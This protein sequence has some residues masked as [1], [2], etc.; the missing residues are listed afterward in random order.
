MNKGVLSV[1][2]GPIQEGVNF[3]AKTPHHQCD[4]SH[5]HHHDHSQHHASNQVTSALAKTDAIGYS[6]G[7]G[8]TAA[9]AQVPLPHFGRINQVGSTVSS[10]APSDS[11]RSSSTTTAEDSPSGLSCGSMST[12]TSTPSPTLS[13]AFS[14]PVQQPHQQ[15]QPQ[16]QHQQQPHHPQSE[17]QQSHTQ[18]H[19]N[20]APSVTR[21]VAKQTRSA[22][23]MPS[24]SESDGISSSAGSSA[25]SLPSGV[26]VPTNANDWQQP[27][28]DAS[29]VIA[30][31]DDM[32]TAPYVTGVA[33]NAVLPQGLNAEVPAGADPTMGMGLFAEVATHPHIGNNTNEITETELSHA[34]QTLAKFAATLDEVHRTTLLNLLFKMSFEAVQGRPDQ[35]QALLELQALALSSQHVAH[36]THPGPAQADT[37][38]TREADVDAVCDADAKVAMKTLKLYFSR[39]SQAPTEAETVAGNVASQIPLVSHTAPVNQMYQTHD[40][41]Q[42]QHLHQYQQGGNLFDPHQSVYHA[43]QQ[44][45]L[46]HQHHHQYQAHH[47]HQLHVQV[48]GLLETLSASANMTT[49]GLHQPASV[50]YHNP[51]SDLQMVDVVELMRYSRQHAI[52]QHMRNYPD[53]VDEYGAHQV[54]EYGRPVRTLNPPSQ[55]RPKDVYDP[56]AL[57][58]YFHASNR[59]YSE[60]HPSALYMPGITDQMAKALSSKFYETSDPIPHSIVYH[61]TVGANGVPTDKLEPTID[62]APIIVANIEVDIDVASNEIVSTYP[63]PASLDAIHAALSSSS[64][65]SGEVPLASFIA[66]EVPHNEVQEYARRIKAQRAEAIVR[67]NARRSLQM[68]QQQLQLQQ[69][70][71]QQLQRAK[72][73]Y[74][75]QRHESQDMRQQLVSEPTGL[76]K[77]VSAPA[78]N[79]A[80]ASG[81][82]MAALV[83]SESPQDDLT[84]DLQALSKSK[85]KLSQCESVTVSLIHNTSSSAIDHTSAARSARVVSTLAMDLPSTKASK[86]GM[87]VPSVVRDTVLTSSEAS[88]QNSSPTNSDKDFVPKDLPRLKPGLD[89]AGEASDSVASPPV[90]STVTEELPK[91]R[92]AYS[93]TSQRRGS[94][95]NIDDLTVN[96]ISSPSL[97]APSIVP[98]PSPTANNLTIRGKR[99]LGMSSR[100]NGIQAPDSSSLGPI[101]PVLAP[102]ALTPHP[103][104]NNYPQ[105]PASSRATR[106]MIGATGALEAA[107]AL[108]SPIARRYPTRSSTSF[109]GPGTEQPSAS[110]SLCS[111]SMVV[112]HT[113]LPSPAL[114]PRVQS[115]QNGRKATLK[116]S[117]ALT[118]PLPSPGS[119]SE[120]TFFPP[121]GQAVSNASFGSARRSKNVHSS[122]M[123]TSANNSTQSTRSP[124]AVNKLVMEECQ[125]SPQPFTRARSNAGTQAK[126]STPALDVL[127]VAVADD[128][129]P[130][131][132]SSSG[133]YEQPTPL[134][135]TTELASDKQSRASPS[136]ATFS[137]LPSLASSGESNLAAIAS[138]CTVR[139]SPSVSSCG[140]S[141]AKP[142]S[143]PGRNP[144]NGDTQDGA[145]PRLGRKRSSTRTLSKMDAPPTASAPCNSAESPTQT[146]DSGAGSTKRVK[147]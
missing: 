74:S 114:P 107:T 90:S 60:V 109:Q 12:S 48:P 106:N 112:P 20:S 130:L 92:K 36:S 132:I 59:G 77:S 91:L 143:A 110:S 113:P 37:A 123:S 84:Q 135:M 57:E 133:Q 7:S 53:I 98:L 119:S 41:R 40:Q 134:A 85:V 23:K 49:N 38:V 11:E 13:N 21:S 50:E 144:S 122:P 51:R 95:S 118:F 29:E 73:A 2:Q 82:S 104:M 100:R 127:K 54:D 8:A 111:A 65:T 83:T 93:R 10:C 142:P 68:Q 115:S 126:N 88:P 16:Q 46:Y 18:H 102:P 31:S 146:G 121:G 22:E 17:P 69:Q 44:A 3:S 71:Q 35:T 99:T 124:S 79:Q 26:S 32:T 139:D 89:V 63:L 125:Q 4:P 80:P 128:L 131:I 147:Q 136:A 75:Q 129:S 62:I 78:G 34:L 145:S 33:V 9:S 43:Q 97:G 70:L 52:I 58:A 96:S 138:K 39:M 66:H 6:L 103:T 137:V 25:D 1:D 76:K 47:P 30:A 108:P 14:D 86:T 72:L 105:L 116:A 15:Q 61:P 94:E 24:T 45:P 101:S 67:A 56:Q 27:S 28:T 81:E 64:F 87:D 140:A 19:A 5:Q 117:G 42:Q 55:N 120:P 141:P